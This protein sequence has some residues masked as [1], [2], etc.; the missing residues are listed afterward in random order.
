MK[1]ENII[2]RVLC[3]GLIYNISI[4][5]LANNQNITIKQ[6]PEFNLSGVN[7]KTYSNKDLNGNK[8][9]LI[10][11]LSNHCK[12]SQIFQQSLVN[13]NKKWNSLGINMF[14]VSPNS[15]KA[16]LPD[17]LAYSDSSDSFLEMI[18]RAKQLNYNFPYIYD[19]KDQIITSSIGAKITPSAYL[20]SS[21]GILVYSGRIGDHENPY[22]YENSE[23]QQKIKQLLGKQKIVYSRTKLHGTAI[24]FKKDILI[25]ENVAK[26]YGR[27]TVSL[28]YAL[29]KKL[30]FFMEQKTNY[31]RF[32]YVWSFEKDN[33]ENRDNLLKISTTYK[34]FRKRG[35]KVFTI[36][37]GK[38]EKH[39]EILEIL[40]QAQL[41]TLNFYTDG[42]EISKIIRMRPQAGDKVLPFCRIINYN[43]TFGYGKNEILNTKDLKS[44][45]LNALNYD[46]V[47]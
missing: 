4:N 44:E 21:E 34:I 5:I 31:P 40:K 37:I 27:E 35:I 13:S 42:T 26:R 19:G 12:F 9:T 39:E 29:E 6:I 23:L 38:P 46:R 43:N 45:F 41:S 14:A 36:C 17:E 32:F 18:D 22:R 10:I 16:I 25:A 11:F 24:K 20:F 30:N 47:K 33:Q 8:G 15:E 1:I 28:N 2:K 7:G 3:I